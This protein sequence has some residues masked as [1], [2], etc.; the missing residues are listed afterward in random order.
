MQL[1]TIYIRKMQIW[2]KKQANRLKE[3]ENSVPAQEG[4][5]IYE[6]ILSWAG[7]YRKAR[8]LIVPLPMYRANVVLVYLK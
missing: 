5:K 2:F 4:L 1:R 8:K 7:T 6:L 3:V